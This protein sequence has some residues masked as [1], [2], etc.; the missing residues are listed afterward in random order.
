MPIHPNTTVEKSAQTFNRLAFPSRNLRRV[1]AIFGRYLVD[2]PAFLDRLQRYSCFQLR[3]MVAP[4]LY[5]S[6][7]A[8]HFQ[9]SSLS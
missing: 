8:A 5:S 3:A 7:F 6:F 9:V 2:G 1:Y 4:T